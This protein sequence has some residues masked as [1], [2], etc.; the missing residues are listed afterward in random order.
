MYQRGKSEPEIREGSILQSE[1]GSSLQTEKVPSCE[2]RR[3]PACKQR[4]APACNRLDAEAVGWFALS[5]Q[6]NNLMK[7]MNRGTV[8]RV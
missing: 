3:A 1:K 4:R 8:W 7:K 2:Q 6:K 5:G